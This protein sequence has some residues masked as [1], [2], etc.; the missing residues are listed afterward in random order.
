MAGRDIDRLALE[1]SGE[2]IVAPRRPGCPGQAIARMDD[3]ERGV[4][5]FIEVF[6][7]GLSECLLALDGKRRVQP[8]P[9]DLVVDSNNCR[10]QVS[11][12]EGFNLGMKSGNEG[13]ALNFAF[14]DCHLT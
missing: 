8:I 1:F 7:N 14:A 5:L 11:G 6:L 3:F 10:V 13:L 2:L 9:D 4:F 12:I